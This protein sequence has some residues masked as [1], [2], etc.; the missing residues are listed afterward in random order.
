M[1]AGI[2]R[3]QN[4][5]SIQRGNRDIHSTIARGIGTDKCRAVACARRIAADGEGDVPGCRNR[6]IA[7]RETAAFY[8]RFATGLRQERHRTARQDRE[9]ATARALKCVP[10]C[11]G[12]YRRTADIHQ[13]G[14]SG[15]QRDRTCCVDDDVARRRAVTQIADA[16]LTN[17]GVASIGGQRQRTGVD[18]DVSAER[19]TVSRVEVTIA[20]FGKRPTIGGRQVDRARRDQDVSRRAC[21]G[22]VT[23]GPVAD[24]RGSEIQISAGGNQR[25]RMTVRVDRDVSAFGGTLATHIAD[26]GDSTVIKC[27][28][29]D[30]SAR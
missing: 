30:Y 18:R 20:D 24:M 16:R 26:F 8:T 27:R 1:R 22:R 21:R 3:V 12:P 10:A 28:D 4:D 19:S 11:I 13:T 14:V 29:R 17:T 15:D 5:F 2:G 7:V 9:I 23:V 6:N 25:K